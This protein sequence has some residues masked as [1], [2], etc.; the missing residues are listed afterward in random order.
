MKSPK[1]LSKDGRISWVAFSAQSPIHHCLRKRCIKAQKKARTTLANGC[2]SAARSKNA[3]GA[4]KIHQKTAVMIP[5]S[6]P[7]EMLSNATRS[8]PRTNLY[9][10][11]WW[12]GSHAPTRLLR[13]MTSLRASSKNGG[14][15][16]RWCGL[17]CPTVAAVVRTAKSLSFTH[18]ETSNRIL[19]DLRLTRRPSFVQTA[20]LAMINRWGQFRGTQ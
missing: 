16:D 17:D 14:N 11:T 1:P 8:S 18:S 2:L 6:L 12:Y 4:L 19:R 10:S 13:C 5:S 15:M 9:S 7:L 20:Y 3:D